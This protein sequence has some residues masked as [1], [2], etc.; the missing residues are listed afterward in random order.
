MPLLDSSQGPFNGSRWPTRTTTSTAPVDLGGAPAASLETPG[1]SDVPPN[2][3]VGRYRLQRE[4]GAGGMGVVYEAYDDELERPLAVKLLRSPLDRERLSREARAL[5]KLSHPNVV[6]IYDVGTFGSYAFIAMELVE[7]TT[8]RKWRTECARELE[9]IVDVM[10]QAGRG[11]AAAHAAGLTHRDF[12]PDNVIVGL[13]GRVRVLDFG[14]VSAID[15]SSA[16]DDF[17]EPDR[18]RSGDAPPVGPDVQRLTAA[19]AL[20]GTPAYMAPE[21]L[22]SQLVAPTADQFSFSVVLWE[23]AFGARPFDPRSLLELVRTGE[24]PE[25]TK[26]AAARAVPSWFTRILERGLSI[27]ASR[28]YPSMVALLAALEAGLARH[29]TESRRLGRRYEILPASAGAPAGTERALDRFTGRLVTIHRFGQPTP[30]AAER[31]ALRDRLARAF[32]RSAS[33]RHPHLIGLLDFGLDRDGSAYLVLDLRDDGE[34][35]AT[36]SRRDSRSRLDYLAQLLQALGHLHKHQ[37]FLGTIEP[38]LILVVD[39][40]V[41]LAPVGLVSHDKPGR[42]CAPEVVAGAPPSAAGDLYAFAAF[43]LWLLASSAPPSGVV[44]VLERLVRPEPTSDSAEDVL[45]ALRAATR[46]ALGAGALETRESR[47]RSAPF[48][49]RADELASLE[50]SMREACRGRGAAWLLTGESGAG[51]SRMLEEVAI[52]GA[53]CGAIVLR[54]QEEREGGSPYRLFRDVFH[55]LSLVTDLEGFEASVLLPIL[56]KLSERLGHSIPPAPEL[57]ARSTHARLLGVVEQVL[58]RQQQPLVLLLE[59]V[60]W[61]RSDSLDLLRRVAASTSSLSVLIVATVRD[62][63]PARFEHALDAM[64]RMHL[65]RLDE[66]VIAQIAE[67]MIGPNGKQAGVLELLQRESEG[68]AFFLV[69]VVRALAEKAGSFERVGEAPLPERVF[70][71]GVQSL[72]QERLSSVPDGARAVLQ[73]AAVIGRRVETQLLKRI[74]PDIDIDD[75][76]TK[77]LDAV[78]LER[79]GEGMRF[80]HDKLREGVLATLDDGERRRLHRSVAEAVELEH[81][82]DPQRYAVLVHHFGQAGQAAKERQYAALAGEYALLNGALREAIDLL[83]RARSGFSGGADALELGRICSTLSDAHFFMTDMPKAMAYAA[84]ATRAV[85]FAFPESKAGR[86]ASLVWQLALHLAYRLFPR[87]VPAR[88]ELRAS[89]SRVASIATAC[90]ACVSITL[91]DTTGVLLYSLMAWNLAERARYPD[92]WASGILGYGLAATGFPRLGRS[93]FASTARGSRALEGSYP[94]LKTSFLLG[95]GELA[96]AEKLA[97]DELKLVRRSGFRPAETFSWFLLGYCAYYRGDLERAEHCFVQA[98]ANE[99]TRAN[100]APGL[101]L[102]RCRTGSPGDVEEMLREALA[103][104]HPAAPRSIAFAVLGLF[105]AQMGRLALAREAADTAVRLA[106]GTKTFGYAGAAF[107]SGVFTVYLAELEQARRDG[108]SLAPA[109]R[110]LR[111]L[112]RHCRA[113]ARAFRVGEPLAL[114]YAGQMA[115]LTERPA[116]ARRAWRESRAVAQTMGLDLYVALAERELE[117][118]G[119]SDA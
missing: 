3:R 54:G 64:R 72:V 117:A 59:D 39:E 20:V 18:E 61:A 47:L 82:N 87:L 45:R 28:R 53:A 85:G 5:A 91:A 31:A 98:L 94:V 112:T 15:A 37:A 73:A 12:K 38:A 92:V 40:Q 11:L 113:W 6:A 118:A 76:L 81:P 58:A 48:L 110:K 74:L 104:I 119:S 84:H 57:D 77:C 16:G 105:H 66:S 101:A 14:I 70:A 89:A 80:R 99:G 2:T 46:L 21:Q 9:E 90:A 44:P 29:T 35:L 69:E 68:N 25:P 33:L 43:A 97:G 36:A 24:L 116:Q 42:F 26:P 107:F 19:G 22:R 8:L 27:D 55:G 93:Y 79:C 71:D 52:L 30:G 86:S 60:Q 108:A 34:D 88:S 96:A 75:G 51:K 95:T 17:T 103:P 4:L 62:D 32:K 50:A 83:E 100:F 49:G 7:G 63:E 102:V 56:P 109:L 111:R 13:D 1:I 67:A 106:A 114:L 115:W 10:L 41:R 78:V 65:G 23:L